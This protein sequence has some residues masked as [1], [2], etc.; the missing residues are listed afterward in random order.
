MKWTVIIPEDVEKEIDN[1][2]DDELINE[3]L[4]KL[5]AIEEDPYGH[6]NKMRDYPYYKFKVRT[7]RGIVTMANR[8]LIINVLRIRPRNIVYRE[9][10]GLG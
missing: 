4:D 10:G 6:L 3:I 7:Y 9:L 5:D 2:N 1:I 8:K